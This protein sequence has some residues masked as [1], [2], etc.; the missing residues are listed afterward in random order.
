M[1][2]KELN[3]LSVKDNVF[4]FLRHELIKHGYRI[5]DWNIPYHMR[6]QTDNCTNV[7]NIYLRDSDIKVTTVSPISGVSEELENKDHMFN[8]ATYFGYVDVQDTIDIILTALENY[9][10]YR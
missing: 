4:I 2:A 1:T 9:I 8:Y 10:N 6:V 5:M 3:D 7:C